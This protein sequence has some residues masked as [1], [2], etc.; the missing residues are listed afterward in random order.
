MVLNGLRKVIKTPEY[1]HAEYF[2]HVLL[3]LVGGYLQLLQSTN[4]LPSNFKPPQIKMQSTKKAPY[5][6]ED[7][8]TPANEDEAST[9]RPDS[10]HQSQQPVRGGSEGTM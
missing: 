4:N 7:G 1:L 9:A 6:R 2:P 3:L 8:A 10:P 5:R